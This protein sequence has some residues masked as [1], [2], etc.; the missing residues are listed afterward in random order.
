MALEPGAPLSQRAGKRRSKEARLWSQASWEEPGRQG[1]GVP[2]L[3][4]H[5]APPILCGTERPSGLCVWASLG[6]PKGFWISLCPL[7]CGNR[8]PGHIPVSLTQ[9]SAGP[10]LTAAEWPWEPDP[11]RRVVGTALC[12]RLLEFM[13]DNTQGAEGRTGVYRWVE[14]GSSSAG[15]ESPGPRPGT[16][17]VPCRLGSEVSSTGTECGGQEAAPAPLPTAAGWHPSL[18][19]GCRCRWDGESANHCCPALRVTRP[20]V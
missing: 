14:G 16:R 15:S 4:G 3:P 7:R 10:A 9:P 12:T 8:N 11:A 2:R 19:F 20:G 17:H 6:V 1:R 5:E 18:G 13:A